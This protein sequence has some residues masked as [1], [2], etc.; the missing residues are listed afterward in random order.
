MHTDDDDREMREEFG[1]LWLAGVVLALCGLAS[2]LDL[3]QRIA[4]R[5][6]G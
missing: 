3:C 1:A 6:R 4:R 5:L 2:V